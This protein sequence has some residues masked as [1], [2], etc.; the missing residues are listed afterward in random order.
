MKWKE[1]LEKTENELE[2][3]LKTKQSELRALRFKAASRELKDVRDIREARS[4]IA[5]ILSLL[6]AKKN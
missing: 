4:V 5:R 1:L 6:S 2:T 3:L